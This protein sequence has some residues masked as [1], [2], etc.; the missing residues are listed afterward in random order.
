MNITFFCP[1]DLQRDVADS[2]QSSL[3]RLL[4]IGNNRMVNQ[5]MSELICQQFAVQATPDYPLAAL[6][7]EFNDKAPPPYYLQADPVHLVM[8]RDAFALSDPST[9][10]ITHAELLAL[11]VVLNQHFMSDGFVFEVSNE[12]LLLRLEVAP[13][14]STTLPEKVVGRNVYSFLP[15]GVDAS[16]WNKILNEIQMLLH[17]HPL[18]QQREMASL[19]V[20]NSIWLSGGGLLP[21]AA[22]SSFNKIYSDMTYVHKLAH[23]AGVAC[24]NLPIDKKFELNQDQILIVTKNKV[25]IEAWFDI[26]YQCVQKGASLQLNLAHQDVVLVSEIKPS[27]VLKFWLLR[28][29]RKNRPINSYFHEYYAAMHQKINGGT[30]F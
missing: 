10:A 7:C 6:S 11:S 5:A 1:I 2:S 13:K 27:H 15:Q 29:L 30:K 20:I 24:Q 19:P 23:L 17:E 26:L 4:T 28:L 16:Y 3:N 18:N 9:L 12:K 8:Q 22:K 14:I 21:I 25:N